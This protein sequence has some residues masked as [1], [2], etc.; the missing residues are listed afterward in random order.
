MSPRET[1]RHDPPYRSNT[2]RLI[3]IAA[4]IIVALGLGS[5]VLAGTV[6][7]TVKDS[8]TNAA[9]SG[10]KV[11][12]TQQTSRYANTNTSGVYSITSVTA[13]TVT[14]TASKSGYITQV[15]GN[16][17]VPSSGTVTAPLI[18]LVKAGTI[19]GTVVNSSGGAA[20][21]GATVKVTGTTTSTTTNSSGVF[22]LYQATGSYTLTVS[23]TGW[24]T[25]TTGSFSVTNNQTTNVGA[26]PLTQTATVTGTVKESGTG[27]VLASV[28]V[29]L[30]SDTS[31][32]ATTNSSGVFTL[33][34]IPVGTQSL[35]LSKSG[36]VSQTTASFAVAAG[37]NNVGDLLLVKSAGNIA[38]VVQDAQ[39]GNAGLAGATV[40]VNSV[41]PTISA[42]T[43][44]DGSFVLAD[45]PVGT[46][47][48]AASRDDYVSATSAPVTVTIGQTTNAGLLALNR[49]T[50]T[51]DGFI[52]DNQTGSPIDGATLTIIERPGVSATSA[53]DGYF[54]LTG[55]TWGV[56][57]LKAVHS[58]HTTQTNGI[59]LPPGGSSFDVYLDPARGTIS[60]TVV[61]AITHAGLSGAWVC[62]DDDPGLGSSTDWSGTFSIPEVPVGSHRLLVSHWPHVT[63]TTEPVD[64]TGEQTAQVQPIEL[65]LTPATISGQVIN[66]A[67]GEP[68]P[69]AIVTRVR[70]EESVMT[71][72]NGR[73]SFSNVTPGWE[74][75]A[76]HR[77]GYWP[78]ATSEFAVW[79]GG[80]TEASGDIRP[81][82]GDYPSGTVHGRV[83][84]SQ[85]Q[86]VGG[87]LVIAMGCCQ[88]LTGADGTYAIEVSRG[89]YGFQVRKDGYRTTVRVSQGNTFHFPY[90]F[91]IVQDFILAAANETGTFQLTTTDPLTLQPREG[92]AD[93]VTLN[94]QYQI[95]SGP[96]SSRAIE[97]VEPGRFLGDAR[98]RTLLPGQTAA[99]EVS[100]AFDAPTTSPAWAAG[101]RAFRSTTLARVA[102]ATV[103][104][105]NPGAAF[106]TTLT[107][108][109]NGR[110][111]FAGGPTGAYAV[112]VIADGNLDAGDPWTFLANDDGSVSI[113]DHE[114]TSPEDAGT[115]AIADPLDGA[116]LAQLPSSVRCTA[117]LPRPDDYIIAAEL[118]VSDGSVDTASLS[119]GP[120]GRSFTITFDGVAA[121]GQ[122]TLEVA[123]LT[124]YDKM[125]VATAVVN[126]ERGAITNLTLTPS[127]VPGGVAALGTVSISDPAPAGGKTVAL[128]SS[129]PAV[130]SVAADVVVPEG[131]TTVEFVVTTAAVSV[132]TVVTISA[133]AGATKTAD[134]LVNPVTVTGLSLDPPSVV[135]GEPSIGTVSLT[136]AAGLGGALIGL[137]SSNPGV[138][139]VPSGVPV[140]QGSL[141]ASF[142]IDTSAVTEST[143]VTIG[144]TAAGTTQTATLTVRPRA[145]S[146]LTLNSTSVLG[147]T[148]C[149]G[150]VTLNTSAPSE[151]FPVTLTTSDPAVAS[152]PATVL[153]AQGETS[154]QFT[155]TTTVVSTPTPVT[156]S[157][158]AGGAIRTAGIEV[159]PLALASVS[160]DPT[161]VSGG[162]VVTGTVALNGP[163]PG[164]G[165]TVALSSSASNVATVPSAVVV[166]GGESTA[167]FTVNTVNVPAS[168]DVVI[169]AQL[170]EAA[171]Y[172]TLTVTSVG[173][174]SVVVYP[175]TVYAGGTAYVTVTLNTPAPSGGVVV[176]LS[177]SN[178]DA[179]AVSPTVTIEAGR[180]SW[181]YPVTTD[182]VTT[183]TPVTIT[184]AAGGT[185]AF[186]PL[187]V[188]PDIVQSIYLY[189][190]GSQVGGGGTF[191]GHA[192]LMA[193]AP[194]AGVVIELA[195]SNPDAANV[196]ASV[197]VAPRSSG[198]DFPV[199]TAVVA[200]STSVTISATT[201]G[202][203][204]Q[205]T[206]TVVP[207]AL[208]SVTLAPSSMGV[209]LIS[210]YNEVNLNGPAGPV[211]VTVGLASS[212]AGVIV[213]A[214]ATVPAGSSSGTFTVMTSKPVCAPT[215]ATI[216]ATRGAD[217][218]TAT[219]T[220]VPSLVVDVFLSHSPAVAGTSVTAYVELNG[221]DNADCP[222]DVT[223]SDSAI[224]SVASRLSNC[225]PVGL[226]RH[227]CEATV[228]TSP[229]APD[230]STVTITASAGGS[231]QSVTLTIAQSAISGVA[232]GVVLPGESVVV[233]GPSFAD[234]DSV[235][236]QGPFD[237]Q[238]PLGWGPVC[239][240]PG[241]VCPPTGIPAAVNQAGDALSFTVP[242][243]L[244]A[245]VYQLWS[246]TSGGVLSNASRWLIVAAQTTVRPVVA[247]GDHNLAEPI[248]AGQT[249]TG[250]LTGDNASGGVAD[251]NFF[252]FVGTAGSTISASMDRADGSKPWEHPDS[253][254]PQIEIMA[255]DGFIYQN[256]VA[257]DNQ[258]G[259]DLNASLHNA[260]LPATGLYVIAAETTRGHGDYRLSFSVNSLAPPAPDDR[261]L[262]FS[263][264]DQTVTVGTSFQTVALTLD[265][266]G[267]PISGANLSYLTQTGPDNQGAVGFIGGPFTL[268]NPDGSAFKD[269]VF[270]A[271]GKAEFSPTF[272]G[273]FSASPLAEGGSAA[274]ATRVGGPI[275]HYQPTAHLAV[276][277]G[278][279]RPN[280]PMALRLGSFERLP[281]ERR[282]AR[283]EVRE[284]AFGGPKPTGYALGP[285]QGSTAASAAAP[286]LNPNLEPVD[287]S[288]AVPLPEVLSHGIHVTSQSITSCLV[289]K[290]PD[291]GTA[292]PVNPPYTVTLNDL[293]PPTTGGPANGLVG[294]DGIHGHRIEKEVLFEIMVK[295]KDGNEPTEPVLIH[296][297]AEGLAHGTII[298]DPE[299]AR[300]ECADATFI[301]H[302]RDAQGQL[303]ARN[304]RFKYRIGT[305]A[306]YVGVVSD[307][308]NPGQM[309]PVWGVAETLAVRLKT[310]NDIPVSFDIHPEPGR[311]DHLACWKTSG[312]PCSDV[313]S[314]WTGS[315]L[316]QEWIGNAYHLEDAFGNTIFG[317]TAT[318]ATPPGS[319]VTAGFT[320]QMSGALGDF[321]Y[322]TLSVAWQKG[323]S[324]PS[325][326]LA[327]TLSVAYPND[328]DWGAGVVSKTITLD[329]T[330][331]SSHALVQKQNY[332]ARF[333]V[334]ESTWPLTVSPGAGEGAM[335]K[336]SVGDTP[337]LVI[338]ALSGS[339]IPATIP[340]SP[341]YLMPAGQDEPS[342]DAQHVYRSFGGTWTWMEAT[343]Q[344]AALEVGGNGAFR[345]SLVDANGEAVPG[346]AFR[347]HACPRAEHLTAEAP[348]G[349]CTLA[350]VDSEKDGQGNDTGVLSSFTLNAAGGQRGYMGIELTKAPI[351]PGTYF[352]LVESIGTTPYRV[353]W[354]SGH[355]TFTTL[356]NDL[357]GMF[358]ICTVTGGEILD[359]N[360]AR[361]NPEIVI[362]QPTQIYVRYL[363]GAGTHSAP[364]MTVN[365]D[366]RWPDNAIY[367]PAQTLELTQLGSSGV[368][369]GGATLTPP[370]EGSPQFAR[371]LDASGGLSFQVPGGPGL[372]RSALV[373]N[374]AVP[375]ATANT[376]VP[377]KLTIQFLDENGQ[378]VVPEPVVKLEKVADPDSP[379]HSLYVERSKARVAAT[380]IGS[381]AV[382]SSARGY[383]GLREKANELL[384][385]R[386]GGIFQYSYA[387][388]IGLAATVLAQYGHPQIGDYANKQNTLFVLV[389]GYGPVMTLDSIAQPRMRLDGSRI[390]T[391]DSYLVAV[392]TISGRSQGLQESD[393]GQGRV[394]QWVDRTT[395]RGLGATLD[396]TTGQND[397]P[398]WL[399][400]IAW[401]G[402]M[403]LRSSTV[404][405]ENDVGNA[406]SDIQRG[407]SAN[408][409]WAFVARGSRIIRFDASAIPAGASWIRRDGA[410]AGT[411]AYHGLQWSE[412]HC[413]AATAKHEA[414]HTW[415]NTL[416]DQDGDGLP[417]V[418]T[419]SDPYATALF[420]SPFHQRLYGQ[421]TEFDLFGRAT[422]DDSWLV[423][424]ARERDAL[425]WETRSA[426]TSIA[427]N[428]KCLQ[429]ASGQRVPGAYPI[430]DF[431]PATVGQPTVLALTADA[432]VPEF[433][434]GL[435]TSN[436]FTGLTVQLKRETAPV[437]GDTAP[438]NP[439]AVILDPNEPDRD[440]NPSPVTTSFG[441]I[442]GSDP[443]LGAVVFSVVPA[444]GLNI[445]S[446][447]A[448]DLTVPGDGS[449]P[450]AKECSTLQPQT[451]YFRIRGN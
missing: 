142:T 57:Q 179:A 117:T 145:L 391:W 242:A 203:T 308:A 397:I 170:G 250:T 342:L 351:N 87:A 309:V 216:T 80:D 278:E 24:V 16:V 313:F 356:D 146:S 18:L 367:S 345:L 209:G 175:V 4:A 315:F 257:L 111:S 118:K 291:L 43:A 368:Y 277:I 53:G 403:D 447:I 128:S 274:Q 287:A 139:S 301:W 51:L 350:P 206:L 222:T 319:Y 247:P 243:S 81:R 439:G 394:Q 427:S 436:L 255:P 191:I 265:P 105:S 172:A 211:G 68:V 448:W 121:S 136:T 251:Y 144:A 99:L 377:R 325:G 333:G 88:A 158:S 60:G 328:P 419:V 112:T 114:L 164:G 213:P 69:D 432:L 197:V 92:E 359:G 232:P 178:S 151:G 115:L 32:T 321:A 150:T 102:G 34:G 320:D 292:T 141:S 411:S 376:A 109:A 224:A 212:D 373:G 166:S 47:S 386:L 405:I 9:I 363:M 324:A 385:P 63:I 134:L 46:R 281:I 22:T 417:D 123:A 390:S 349:G 426:G 200:T 154:A 306:R 82:D 148:S 310:L 217:V 304:E 89:R 285:N 236:V 450:Q 317:D 153:V 58:T 444:A 295:D 293:T 381:G 382:D 276:A 187:T 348:P 184:A 422:A 183:P 279:L 296:L 188:L 185:S 86:P 264:A 323:V 228:T 155:V 241:G 33:T 360:Y 343:Q 215:P 129:D 161:S 233:Y 229:A 198:V 326:P 266:R 25:A 78:T 378:N 42:T 61:D 214:S 330:G 205:A 98:P 332:D 305:W 344:D 408:G 270:T 354:E 352:I 15:T 100:S 132:P 289:A 6:T 131:A 94:S 157:A 156:V 418:E 104:L 399:E 240:L 366:T 424:D 10:V 174:A 190:L 365:L 433:R 261:V 8:V 318:S 186:A 90:N 192:Y 340:A 66:G 74:V 84:D 260:V 107:T 230:G 316:Y 435:P 201:G 375:S 284:Q 254:D 202:S 347:V 263:G 370:S 429:A 173:I 54:V 125:L 220:V 23:L 218:V 364:T 283:R 17:V 194:A 339:D 75:L 62:L 268:T 163:A 235:V 446:A 303:V 181:A 162:A 425:R 423:S 384:D 389:G 85:G 416:L 167:S 258:P 193:P 387:E 93:V 76:F 267:Y 369:L 438:G 36:Y 272:V 176:S 65:D 204:R 407:S 137:T 165:V 13:G 182:G 159:G 41:T 35:D 329:F 300:T 443:A 271:P 441:T 302:E 56:I 113:V 126:L 31:K 401:E 147:G 110:W 208:T 40:T 393:P 395:T 64:V 245:G 307:P 135:G 449:G 20:V 371:T 237:L 280:G 362:T 335:P 122:H 380:L 21:S 221:W 28:S 358:A 442:T 55:V 234:G 195:S 400:A 327:T 244:Q 1:N 269:V 404:S 124:A 14:L 210:S 189:S 226:G 331:G 246:K 5:Q 294:V 357:V 67:T 392:P 127:A 19:T 398:D 103:T 95:S 298:L 440:G 374:A 169:S 119:Y 130:A 2:R 415:Q 72:G 388:K 297:T 38:G 353:R 27:T 314:F 421:N 48:V 223:S 430:Y 133:T 248:V 253:L 420:D 273:T 225:G 106:S 26:I 11:M 96:T 12:V 396:V 177:S 3:Q 290:F 207:L 402:V 108:D 428:L 372:V 83:V 7:G 52:R 160:L 341:I 219:L 138:A 37:T 29:K 299:G 70:N 50:T 412:F 312:V 227:R 238:D 116:V 288:T 91:E 361:I 379:G 286:G 120:D 231:H 239:T 149:T 346:T 97:G 73:F 39:A 168:T 101:G 383:A 311:P 140:A 275:P 180:T 414:R 445:F 152:V 262:A 322:Y 171:R 44:A 336:T 77:D 249:V 431:G 410:L 434:W 256:L 59:D 406:V 413:L 451:I 338:L 409:E 45:V 79:S 71:D 437:P 143:Q 199:T 49:T 337:R 252:Y 259:V 30:H 196:P 282:H 355:T 334:D